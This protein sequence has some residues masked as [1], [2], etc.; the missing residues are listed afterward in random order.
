MLPIDAL[1]PD[2]RWLA[3]RYDLLGEL[4]R[5][6]MSVVYHA[7]DRAT[8]AEV[9]LKLLGGRREGDA[10]AADRF[11][12]AARL[13]ATLEHP[14]IVRTLGVVERG[15]VLAV[16]QAFVPG[17]TLRAALRDSG[18][19]P[20]DRAVAV[21]RDVAAAL[22]HAHTRRVVHRDVKPENVLLD[23]ASGHALL[24]DFGIAR[25]LDEAASLTADGASLGTPAYMAPE[26]IAGRAVDERT[27]VYALGL[28]GWELLTGRRPW[29]GETLYAV[30]HHQQHDAL[31]DLAA[32]RPDIPAFLLDALR[33]ALHKAPEARWRDGAT[34][35]ERLT[36]A[37]V[38][39]P[40]LPIMDAES[41]A[42]A[43]GAE[44]GRTMQFVH[45]ERAVEGGSVDVGP[46]G[47]ARGEGTEKRVAMHQ[48]T[49]SAEPAGGRWRAARPG[50][51]ARAP[52]ALAGLALLAAAAVQGRRSAVPAT[53]SADAERI[54]DRSDSAPPT[55]A[56]RPT[57]DAVLDALLAE[58]GAAARRAQDDPS[59]RA[60]PLRQTQS[61]GE[62][63]LA[64]E[65]VAPR[66]RDSAASNAGVERGTT[67]RGATGRG[68][69]FGSRGT[70]SSVP[71]TPRSDALARWCASPTSA[72]QRACL[73][74]RIARDDRAL[75]GAY[76]ALIGTLR[77]LAGGD[78]EPAAV[79]T[80]RAEQRRWLA[81]R[82]AR[83]RAGTVGATL[84][85]AARAP[86]FAERSAR[87]TAE[88]RERR[89]RLVGA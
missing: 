33:G 82:D 17:Q 46:G 83:C 49:P 30:L 75:D 1:A 41:D 21:L 16:V 86:C 70:A 63:A 60:L 22:A 26:Q 15:G 58:A 69:S 45:G 7:R 72:D 74:G 36:P 77:Q 47:D 55:P 27:D 9:A 29:Q 76:Q 4:G 87:R 88:L 61:A 19:L 11:A 43:A 81:E 32:L 67:A 40:P 66:R 20:F 10:E 85:G 14:R 38:A 56:V 51:R 73:L 80:L 3:E 50:R 25:P 37:P 89:R 65:R 48:T 34:M 53:V 71:A 6:G 68:A 2:A 18:A 79:R 52:L 44:A 54:G 59:G 13:A 84:W 42:S 35:L 23:A 31:P 62:V 39:L 12:R 5:G 64:P 24:G 28:L 57:G 78:R 8:G